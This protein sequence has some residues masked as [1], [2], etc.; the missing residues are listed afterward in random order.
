[1]AKQR[2]IIEAG[3]I[4]EK[5]MSGVG[6]TALYLIKGLLADEAFLSKFQ[7][8]LIVPFNKVHLVRSHN[9][10]DDVRI[11][12]L[13][14]PGKIMNG[15]VRFGMLPYM[16]LFFGRGVYLFPNFKNWPLLFS[17]NLTY[18]HDVYFKVEP[19][20]IEPRNLD[21]LQR[22]TRGFI[23]RADT[24]VTVSEHAKSEIEQYFPESE[25]KVEVVHN[26]IDHELFYPR[27]TQEQQE[28]SRRYDLQP[29]K[30]FMFFSNIEP[31]KNV[32]TLLDAYK[33]CVDHLKDK[34][35]ALLLVG[36]MG[37]ANDAIIAKMKTLQVDGYR[38]IKPS[39]YVP[40]SEIPTLLSGAICLVHPAVYEGFGL[41][42]LEAMACG[43]QVVVG[44]NSSLPEV[45]G[46]DYNEY[47]D[48]RSPQA[49][50][51]AMCHHYEY[52]KRNDYGLR[53]AQYFSWEKSASTLAKVI[54][55]KY[56]N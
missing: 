21:L 13:F 39:S 19:T 28:V 22:H 7:I 1:M 54:E 10:P 32:E 4:A 15:L 40:D 17:R 34:S 29:G 45:M 8:E 6:H 37:W 24:V 44:N 11:Q 50:S 52:P 14:L 56:G 48:V 55:G 23:K 42:P 41:T 36:G 43:T 9:L 25:G 30:Y 38:V 5:N 53:Q 3:S 16:D 27:T 26:G 35:I 46:V 47:V 31:R 20:H 2:L 33:M 49:I 12:R 18:I 51:N